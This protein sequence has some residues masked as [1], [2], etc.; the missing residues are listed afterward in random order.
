MPSPTI[1]RRDTMGT[2]LGLLPAPPVHLMPDSVKP[3][4]EAFEAASKRRHDARAT[5][6]KLG[7]TGRQAAEHADAVALSEAVDAG[8]PDPGAKHVAAFEVELANAKRHA[9]AAEHSVN[10]T[11][12]ALEA[13]MAAQSDDWLDEAMERRKNAYSAWLAAVDQLQAA[14]QHLA[15]S[16]A[17]ETYV[18]G[19]RSTYKPGK[20]ASKVPGVREHSDGGFMATEIIEALRECGRDRSGDPLPMSHGIPLGKDEALVEMH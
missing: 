3:L 7:R 15:E 16:I 12:S 1:I 8:K 11:A 5:L 20:F 17:L 18:D 14:H 4:L 2:A 6:S 13:E 9:M 19:E 10:T